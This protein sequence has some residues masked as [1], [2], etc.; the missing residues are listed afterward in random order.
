VVSVSKLFPQGHLFDIAP[1]HTQCHQ[2][3][4][5]LRPQEERNKHYLDHLSG[6]TVAAVVPKQERPEKIA[7]PI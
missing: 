1:R 3:Y 6:K 7:R 2:V 5:W 4:V